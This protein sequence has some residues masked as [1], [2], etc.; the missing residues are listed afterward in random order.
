ME[1]AGSKG[2]ETNGLVPIGQKVPAVVGTV[3]KEAWLTSV[4]QPLRLR[5]EGNH[6]PGR[7]DRTCGLIL[8]LPF[9]FPVPQS[10]TLGFKVMGKSV[11]ADPSQGRRAYAVCAE[12]LTSLDPAQVPDQLP[13]NEAP[14]P[15]GEPRSPNPSIPTCTLGRG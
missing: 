3:L 13:L 6:N 9:H 1:E 12:E 15:R 14:R 8:V 2:T 7:G 4:P 10:P 11:Q 5:R